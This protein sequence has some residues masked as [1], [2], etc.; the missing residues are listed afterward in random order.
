[1]GFTEHSCGHEK[2]ILKPCDV[3]VSIL[4]QELYDVILGQV[5]MDESGRRGK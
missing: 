3:A 4:A 5:G 1:M 2:L